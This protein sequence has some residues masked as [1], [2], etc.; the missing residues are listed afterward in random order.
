M[1]IHPVLDLLPLWAMF[2]LTFALVLCSMEVG[3]WLGRRR[4]ASGEHESDAAVGAMA[5]A[6]LALL[7]F[8]L[9]FVFSF[10]ASRVEVRR[11]ALL[12][13]VNAIGT[14]YLRAATLTEP[15][16][17]DA[18]A[19][20]REYVDVRLAG[21]RTHDVDMILR[22]SDEL[23]RRLWDSAAALALRTPDSEIVALYL[24]TLNQ[25]IDLHARRLN[26]GWRVRIPTLVW[27]VLFLLTV[28]AMGE[29]GYQIGLSGKRR[30]R[31]APAFALAFAAVI[32]LIAD[33]DRI[34]EGWLRVSQLPMEEL[35]ASMDPAGA[36][37]P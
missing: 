31:T 6:S 32:V 18:R 28:L 10:A 35:R 29:M 11:T 36:P 24:E 7:A 15:E 20:L 16:R 33:L 23:H 13:E 21:V 3:F 4:A 30:A 17:S 9:A 26:E 1:Q 5:S 14:T 12:D 8:L 34:G 25:V 37:S 27:A 2:P 19:L 22:R